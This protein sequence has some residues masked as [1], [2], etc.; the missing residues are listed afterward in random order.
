VR[1]PALQKAL[2]QQRVRDDVADG[3][4]VSRRQQTRKPPSLSASYS[5]STRG[6]ALGQHGNTGV[7]A[8][9]LPGQAAWHRAARTRNAHGKPRR[10]AEDRRQ[11]GYSSEV[12]PIKT[13]RLGGGGRPPRRS[14]SPQGGKTSL[15][16]A[17]PPS[18]PVRVIHRSDRLNDQARSTLSARRCLRASPSTTTSRRSAAA[19]SK[20]EVSS[21][22]SCGRSLVRHQNDV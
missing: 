4:V 11:G 6:T 17:T 8:S 19:S 10:A 15:S 1:V 18:S 9:R 22:A 21:S 16:W 7:R 5:A 20:S 14:R 3:N 12:F 2:V 13:R